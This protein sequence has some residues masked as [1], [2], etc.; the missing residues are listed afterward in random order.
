MIDCKKELEEMDIAVDA[1]ENQSTMPT[2]AVIPDLEGSWL[3]CLVCKQKTRDQNEFM[4][5]KCNLSGDEN[6]I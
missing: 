2:T 5:H 3:V 4:E 6:L 1:R